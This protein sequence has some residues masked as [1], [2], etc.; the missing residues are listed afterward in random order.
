M[1]EEDAK[2]TELE[3][4]QL[5]RKHKKKM[6]ID[7][8]HVQIQR[9]VPDL[10][11]ER[12]KMEQDKWYGS[13]PLSKKQEFLDH[14]LAGKNLGEAAKLVGIDTE[15]ASQVILRNMIEIFPRKVEK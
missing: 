3:Y 4:A 11:E 1:K 13:V 2:L 8:L 12:R 9:E 5:H 6:K 15:I 14:M 10:R 7:R